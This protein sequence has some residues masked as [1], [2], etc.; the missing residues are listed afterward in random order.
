MVRSRIL[1]TSVR[2]LLPVL[3]LFAFFILARGHNAPGGGFI[4]GLVVAAAFALVA[5]ANHA[6][7]ARVIL[8]LK[9]R[10]FIAI[11]LLIVLI[12]AVISVL[13]GLPALTGLWNSALF[14]PIIGKLGTPFLFDIGVFYVVVGVV[15]LIIFSLM[16]E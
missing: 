4:A 13:A 12:S 6:R 15:L 1:S 5:I 3:L 16:E 14:L 8:W 10:V 11:G 7:E 9:P 2:Y